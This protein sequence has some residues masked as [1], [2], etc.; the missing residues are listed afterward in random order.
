MSYSYAK[1]ALEANIASAEGRIGVLL[2]SMDQW[3][4]PKFKSQANHHGMLSPETIKAREAQVANLRVNIR[5]WQR[6][7]DAI[8]R[9]EMN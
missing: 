7:L 1:R 8:E 2:S 4:T 3:N 9:E 5:E 6:V